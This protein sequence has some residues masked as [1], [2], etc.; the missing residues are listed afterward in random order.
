ML[1]RDSK[2]AGSAD[3]DWVIETAEKNLGTDHN[4]LR[5]EFVQLAKTARRISPRTAGD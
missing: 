3:W 4:G 1:L 2:F 5:A